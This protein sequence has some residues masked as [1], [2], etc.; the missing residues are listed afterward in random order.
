[1]FLLLWCNQTDTRAQKERLMQYK[2]LYFTQI[3]Q[4]NP[5]QHV[6]AFGWDTKVW[7]N[8]G[9]KLAFF[10]K[11][12]FV[13]PI[14]L[15]WKPS[16]THSAWQ[17]RPSP[18]HLYLPICALDKCSEN[19]LLAV[20]ADRN[21]QRKR[22]EQTDCGD[23]LASLTSPVK[24]RGLTSESE[25]RTSVGRWDGRQQV[26]KTA[27]NSENLPGWRVSLQAVWVTGR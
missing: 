11:I 16:L 8:Q 12:W 24:L 2:L 9:R 14:A 5:N 4:S 20:N 22:E 13:P 17:P 6:S 1:M 18:P 3:F 7:D 25:E 10:F 21:K 15:C 23:T 26:E 19:G 27:L